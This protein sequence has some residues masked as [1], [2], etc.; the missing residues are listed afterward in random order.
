MIPNGGRAGRPGYPGVMSESPVNESTESDAES[1]PSF[2]LEQ[3]Q[4]LSESILWR[5]QRDFYADRG[6]GAWS[7]GGVP[8]GN[9]T[10]PHIARAYA[11]IALGYLRDVDAQMDPAQPLFIVELGAGS[12]RF[13]FRFVK[14]LRRLLQQAS[15]RHKSFTYVMTDTSN[16]TI[17]YWQTHPSLRPLVEA[18]V[19]DFAYFDATQPANIQT[20]NSHLTLAPGELANPLLVLAN[21]VFD[22]IPHDFFTIANGQILE[23]LVKISAPWPE[24]ALSAAQPLS[25]LVI[26]F[27]RR[28]TTSEYYAE[29]ALNRVLGTY[30]QWLADGPLLF[31]VAAMGAVRFF[32]ELSGNRVLVLAG[33]IGS[34]REE[35]V[36][37]DSMGGIGRDGNFWI[38]VNFD[39]LGRYVG[40]LGGHV[41]H[42]PHRHLRLNISAF[43][44]GDSA[45]GFGETGLAYDEA[46]AQSGPDDFFVL[47]QVTAS[48]FASMNRDE[49]LAFLRSTGWES[50]YAVQCIPFLIESLQTA[51][52]ATRQDLSRAI[53]DAWDVYYPI[54]DGGDLSFW[55]GALSFH[56]EDYPR[57]LEYFHRSLELVGMDAQTTC[58]IGLCLFRLG[59]LP[60][61]VEWLDRTLEMNPAS[62]TARDM[63]TAVL[64]ALGQAEVKPTPG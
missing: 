15:L 9:T 45:T 13:G 54:G 42:P 53:D 38:N 10:T 39:A 27:E 24:P 37:N 58:N 36:G 1:G 61:A 59:R 44:L 64:G 49:L 23:N 29:Q 7:H 32:Q 35:D 16:S 22:S 28:P 60:E 48:G 11:R 52:A 57:A 63:R 25:D 34:A 5:L 46:I 12:G 47:T 26:S 2:V 43:A 50:D 21:Y 14:R 8:Q 51:S 19:V 62:E 56:L 6:I 4:R 40:E 31:P 20:I 18:G 30:Q 3:G 55:L 17:D 33:D 41:F